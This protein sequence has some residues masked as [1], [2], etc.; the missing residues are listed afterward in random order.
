MNWFARYSL[1]GSF[2]IGITIAWAYAFTSCNSI[3]NNDSLKVIGGI[4]AGSFLPIGYIVSSLSHYLYYCNIELWPL[5]LI[6]RH[7]NK[8]IVPVALR[9]GN[10]SEIL[11][12]TDVAVEL[13]LNNDVKQTKWYVELIN[14]RWATI[15]INNNFMLTILL[16]IIACLIAC[17][18]F[19]ILYFLSKLIAIGDVYQPAWDFIIILVVIEII[20][21]EIL[22]R[23][24]KLI[25]KQL[26]EMFSKL[27]EF[28][29][30][31]NSK[32]RNSGDRDIIE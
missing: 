29:I 20:I 30:Q 23:Y 12:E 22:R 18:C 31:N 3:W 14:K 11:L 24:T 19:I 16:S 25:S 5:K 2:F 32:S 9:S 15:S 17:L 8:K 27:K 10:P 6:Y 1:T 4:A 7:I 21:F 26:I 28:R 13:R